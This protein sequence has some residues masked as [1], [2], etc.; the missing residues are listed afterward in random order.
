MSTA[1][2][3]LRLQ[4]RRT[5]APGFK[6]TNGAE[7]MP[8][9]PGIGEQQGEAQPMPVEFGREGAKYLQNA[10]DFRHQFPDTV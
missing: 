1:Q 3:C 2:D 9:I 8:A 6:Q 5:C 10:G 4:P 7:Q